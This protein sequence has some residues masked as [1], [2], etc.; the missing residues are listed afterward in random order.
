MPRMCSSLA[1]SLIVIVSCSKESAPT[2]VG[3]TSDT[4]NGTVSDT[5]SEPEPVFD[6][7]VSTSEEFAC[8]I[9]SKGE[10][11]CWG[12]SFYNHREDDTPPEGTFVDV[13]VGWGNACALHQGGSVECWG[14]D[15]HGH[16]PCLV[17][18]APD[19]TFQ[20]VS[21]GNQYAC[22]L[23]MDGA[24]QCW[25]DNPNPT[26]VPSGDGYVWVGVNAFGPCAMTVDGLIRCVAP[27]DGEVRE[28]EGPYLYADDRAA[29]CCIDTDFDIECP[30]GDELFGYDVPSGDFTQVSSGE[31]H[32]CALGTDGHV[33]C[34]SDIEPSSSSTLSDVGQISDT[35][36]DTDFV[37]VT[38][39][40]TSSCGV[41]EDGEVECWGNWEGWAKE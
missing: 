29:L 25:G 7:K 39:G 41:H 6:L 10:L 17:D 31:I 28:F 22:A 34:W 3:D 38:A 40:G 12:G 26:F 30:L 11:S 18:T 8:S 36:S 20:Q 27:D 5:A 1:L 33:E 21:V 32:G 9:N 14:D 2:A 13:S 35:P 23:D 16:Y 4:A 24:V 15:C 19:G 37:L